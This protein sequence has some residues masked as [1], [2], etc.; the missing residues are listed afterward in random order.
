[1]RVLIAGLLGGIVFFFW[2]F[3]AHMVLPIGEMGM[4][5]ATNEDAVLAALPASLPGEGVYMIPGLA[6]EKMNDPAASAAYSA[7]AAANPNAFIIYQPVGRDGMAMTPNLIKQ[8]VFD[9]ISAIIVA[10][11]LALGP[12]AFGKRVMVATALGLFSWLTV[13]VPY[14]NWY[15]FP[16]DFT[17][18]SLLEQVV[19]WFFA[20]L[21]I[22]WWLG[23]RH[24]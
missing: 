22:A 13:S 10:F 14:W 24:R 18:G 5:Q 16:L 1:M 9:T 15:R 3:V 17:M 21:A 7:K 11:V 12:F 20:G 4:R 19:G 6:P 8:F 23:R 2:G